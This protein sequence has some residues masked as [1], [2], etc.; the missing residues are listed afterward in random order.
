MKRMSLS[1]SALALVMSAIASGNS[2][3]AQDVEPT[4]Q[5]PIDASPAVESSVP[6]DGS[7]PWAHEGRAGQQNG[8]NMNSQ[9]RLHAPE[10]Q[11]PVSNSISANGQVTSKPAKNT[12]W[13]QKMNPFGRGGGETAATTTA[14]A[15]RRGFTLG[16]SGA[17]AKR[18]SALN[19]GEHPSAQAS[20]HMH[21][22]S[23]AGGTP[24][25]LHSQQ[26]QQDAGRVTTGSRSNP[27]HGQ[28]R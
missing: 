7:Q 21:R 6:G 17:N 18:A 8:A 10:D 22:P 19:A 25:S 23:W 15:A 16:T 4:V 13:W 20:Q 2:V 28:N 3:W 9:R 26:P 27:G 11:M 5:T 1:L 14:P 24:R 12:S